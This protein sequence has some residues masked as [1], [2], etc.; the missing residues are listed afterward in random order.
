MA[1]QPFFEPWPLIQFLDL[2]H[3]RWDSLDGES[4]RRKAATYTQNKRTQTSIPSV[5]FEP[6]ITAFE[7]AKTVHV[8]DIAATVIGTRN[9][10]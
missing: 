9:L 5:G 4:A 10:T 2:L 7:R 3:I 6:I 1:L 8:S